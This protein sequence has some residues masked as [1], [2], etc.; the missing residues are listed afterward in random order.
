MLTGATV[1]ISG[2]FASGEDVLGFVAQNGIVGSYNATTGVLTLSGSASVAD[3]EAALQSVTYANSSDNPSGATRTISF[4][5]DDGATLDHASNVATASVSVTPVNDAS[6]ATP[7]AL[8]AIAED[9]GARIITQAELLAGVTDVDNTSAQLTITA[10]S[11][12]SANGTLVDNGDHTWT[13][14]PASNDDTSVSFSYTVSDGHLTASSTASLDITPVNDAPVATIGQASYS[15]TEQ[16]TLHLHGTGL[17]ISDVD[18]GSGSLSVTLAVTEGVITIFSGSTGVGVSNSGT[19]SV[20]V[21]GTLTQINDLLAGNGGATVNYFDGSDSP[22][23]SAT[24]TLTVHDNGNTGGGDLSSSDTATINITPVN[25]GPVATIAHTYGVIEQQNLTI[26]GTGLSVSDVDAGS[27]SMTVTLSVTEGV[28]NVAAGTSGALVG[29]SGTSSVT[30]TGSQSQIN[31]LLAGQDSATVVYNDNLDNPSSSVTLTLSVHDN[32]NTGGGDLSSSA[33]TTITVAPVNDAPVATPVTLTAIAEDSGAR[34]ITQ[35][36]LLAGVSDPDNAPA[37]LSIAALNI[38]SG[39]GSLVDNGDHTWT[40]TPAL[41]DDTGVTFNYTVSDGSQIASSTASLDITPVN[42]A[43]VNTVPGSQSATA[44][45]PL[46][47][48]GVSVSDID[49]TNLTTNLSVLHGT[50]SVSSVL[51]LTISGSGTGAVSLSGTQAQINSALAGLAYTGTAGYS[52]ADTLSVNTSDGALFDLDTVGIT[53]TSANAA[54]TANTDLIVIS[55]NTSNVLVPASWLLSNDHDPD[56]DALSIT[57]LSVVGSLPSGWTLTPITS[58]GIVSGLNVTTSNATNQ[59]VSISYAISDGYGHTST[60]TSILRTPG[61]TS[62]NGSNTISLNGIEYNYSYVDAGQGNDTVIGGSTTPITLAGTVG[63][64]A[65]VGGTGNDVLD[66]K[67]G[68]N[69][70]TG[71]AGSDDFVISNWTGMTNHI[72]D[73]EAGT[74]VT[75]VDHLRFDVGVSL[76]EFS[77]GNNNTTVDNFKLASAGATN[78]AGAEVVVNNNTSFADGNAVQAYIDSHTNITQ[79]ALF[80]VYNSALG[81]AGVYYDANA[82]AA[83]GAVLVA[84]IDN[85]TSASGLSNVNSGDF[86]FI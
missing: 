58:G 7:V 75:S 64:D 74:N 18:A 60:I 30:I 20:T 52:G 13:Y 80:V 70:L 86:I 31:D 53:V 72:T 59:S 15:A 84:E 27:G 45:T 68:A 19:S 25:D 81:H 3:Y 33:T 4:Q 23:A 22:A 1:S 62:S 37:D 69:I 43:P 38:A 28:L 11:L 48:G 73:F 24:L 17:S 78:V 8:A 10:L 36:E 56:G 12:T 2:G 51:G 85:I 42:D 49:S 71:N 40:Y 26:H 55:N 82:N 16:L 46:A 14:T 39:S 57:S 79:G 21:N 65:F 50:L 32:G 9:S 66:A 67:G 6:V 77:V 34:I 44:G 5:V 41:N 35:A 61:D 63:N 29:N 83:G 76:N 47:L 54:P